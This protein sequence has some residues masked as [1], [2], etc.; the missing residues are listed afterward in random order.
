MGH[1]LVSARILHQIGDVCLYQLSYILDDHHQQI[2]RRVIDAYCTE[3]VVNYNL[4]CDYQ[5][6]PAM[7]KNSTV[8]AGTVLA[9]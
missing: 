9:R 7:L 6:L 3:D 1:V 5:R 8:S 2:Y 4:S